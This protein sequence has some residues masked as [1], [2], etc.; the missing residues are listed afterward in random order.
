MAKYYSLDK[1]INVFLNSNRLYDFSIFA[2]SYSG[3][4]LDVICTPDKNCFTRSDWYGSLNIILGRGFYPL[5]F[6][7][8]DRIDVLDIKERY[9][10]MA[11]CYLAV[12]YHEFFHVLYTDLSYSKKAYRRLDRDFVNFA[13]NIVNI[14]EDVTIEATGKYYYPASEK[15]LDVLCEAHFKQSTIDSVSNLIKTDPENPGT[16]MSFL[17]LLAR[18]YDI[19][20]LPPYKLYQDNEEFI[21]WGVYKCVNTINAQSRFN[22]QINFANQLLKI[23][24]HKPVDK[25]EVEKEGP[26]IPGNEERPSKPINKE[27]E[28][29]L[30]PTKATSQDPYSWDET[31]NKPQDTLDNIVDKNLT[32]QKAQREY[33]ETN[34]GNS[35]LEGTDLTKQAITMLANDDPV[36]RYSHKAARLDNYCKTGNYLPQYKDVVKKYEEQIRRVVALIRKMKGENNTSWNRFQMKGKFD[37]SSTIK[38][39]NYKFFKTKNAPSQEADLVFEILVDNSGS[40]SGKKSRLAGEALII[41]A[42]ALHR[43]H[44]P[45]AVDAF[46]QGNSCI[47]IKLKEFNDNY[48]KVK[49][50]M[51]LLTE[52]FGVHDLA[53]FSGNIDE[54]NLMYVRDILNQQRQQDKV[55]IVISDG[56]TCGSYKDLKKVA[57][58]ME[59]QGITVLGIGIFDNNVESIYK[60][61]IILKTQQD[62]EGLGAFLNKYLVRKI[63]K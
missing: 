5:I 19:T 55:C 37:V 24:N 40:M 58:S 44:I 63:F 39:G 51:T 15:Y 59:V 45:F 47:T 20:K 61:H 36:T 17:L 43:L 52:Q 29:P 33:S 14:L 2:R 50:N 7:L 53:T 54:V 56:A 38:R 34:E 41:F 32:E 30:A 3:Q 26:V 6:E 31:K 4:P 11:Q 1:A 42:E 62:L 28:G 25:K 21:K 10:H 27:A 13:H 57:D 16:L 35:G 49:T 22:R 12:F 60:N 18:G 48:N 46:T 23:L 9:K 8:E